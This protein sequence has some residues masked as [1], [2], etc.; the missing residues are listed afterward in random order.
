MY[1]SLPKKVQNAIDKFATRIDFQNKEI[2][3]IKSMH[4]EKPDNSKIEEEIILKKAW[5]SIG[6]FQ[7]KTAS[8]FKPS[9]D[10]LIF[11]EDKLEQYMRIQDEVSFFI[12]ISINLQYSRYSI[13]N[14]RNL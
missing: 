1:P 10:Q 6:N 7:L 2:L 5:E 14:D 9:D 8:D 3:R 13:K 12:S 11:I 4:N